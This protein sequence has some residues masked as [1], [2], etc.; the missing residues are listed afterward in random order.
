[1][2]RSMFASE[3]DF[4]WTG[5]AQT[6]NNSENDRKNNCLINKKM[7]LHWLRSSDLN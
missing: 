3:I 4:Q 7:L 1:M 6:I 5:I 2:N